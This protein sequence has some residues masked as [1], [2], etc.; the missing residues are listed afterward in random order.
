MFFSSQDIL[1][2][3]ILIAFLINRPYSNQR[4][5]HPGQHTK[6]F[7]IFISFLFVQVY[8]NNDN[9]NSNN[10]NNNKTSVDRFLVRVYIQK[11]I[12]IELLISTNF[13]SVTIGL[14]GFMNAIAYGWTRE[15]FVQIITVP[16]TN[17]EVENDSNRQQNPK[18]ELEI[19]DTHDTCVKTRS[20]LIETLYNYSSSIESDVN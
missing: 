13:Q 20:S 5:Y 10:N 3:V 17:E 18:H 11:H 8:Y 15:D 19:S 14:Q 9:N 2:T 7:N 4:Q 1:V 6:R 16:L 12:N